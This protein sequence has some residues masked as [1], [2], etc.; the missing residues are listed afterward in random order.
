MLSDPTHCTDCGAPLATGVPGTRCAACLGADLFSDLVAADT[1]V[2]NVGGYV[3]LEEFGRGGMGVVY[4]ARHERLGREAA[5]KLILSGALASGQERQ[6]FL[7][8]MAA[9]AA[10]DHPNIVPVFEAGEDGGQLWYAMRLLAGQSLAGKLRAAPQQPL[11]AREAAALVHTLALAVQHAHERGFIHRDLKPANILLDETGTPH[12]ADFGLARRVD[13]AEHLT[14]TGSTLGT[15]AYMAPEQA[16]G[17]RQVTTAADVYSLGAI[18]YELLAG[19]APF[20]GDSLTDVL[21]A[22]RERDPAALSRTDRDLDI[23]CRKCL[24]KEPARRYPSALALAGD[25]QHWL[26]GKPISARA[27]GRT[28]RLVRWCR[29]RPAIAGLGAAVVLLFLAGLCGVLWQWNRANHEARTAT[30]SQ[31][32]AEAKAKEAR[33]ALYAADMNLAQAA[34]RSNNTGRARRLLDAHRPAPGADDLRGWEWRYLWDQCRSR[35]TAVLR[36]SGGA[37]WGVA[38]AGGR[39]FSNEEDGTLREFDVDA[40]SQVKKHRYGFDKGAL[41][42]SPDGRRFIVPMSAEKAEIWSWPEH[43]V[44]ALAV[45]ARLAKAAWSPDGALAALQCEDG[46]VRLCDAI[47]GALR[48]EWK[49][50]ALSFV[51]GGAL[52]FLPGDPLRLAVGDG[53]SIRIYRIEDGALERDW[54]AHPGYGLTSLAASP[55]GRWLVSSA[56]YG[57]STIRVWNAVTGNEHARL[58]AHTSWVSSLVFSL[59]GSRLYGAGADQAISV[60]DAAHWSHLAMLRGHTDEIWSLALAGD[61]LVSGA[62]NGEVMLWS[63]NVAA[64]AAGRFVFPPET[65]EVL[66]AGGDLIALRPGFV[67]RWKPGEWKRGR[68]DALPGGTMKYTL[69][70][71]LFIRGPD[72]KTKI[73]DAAVSPPE[74]IAE[75]DLPEIRGLISLPDETVAVLYHQEGRFTIVDRSTRRTHAVEVPGTVRTFGFRPEDGHLLV[76]TTEQSGE[77]FFHRC[78]YK[79][80]RWLPPERVAAV[81]EGY[82]SDWRADW[83]ARVNGRHLSVARAHPFKPVLELDQENAVPS[84]AFSRDSRWL[85]VA[86]ENAWV[87][88]W[89]LPETGAIPEPAILRGHLNSVHSL[90]FTPDSTRLVTLCSNREAAKFWDPATGQELLT[91]SGDATLLYYARFAAGGTTLLAS[92]PVRGN[93]WQA[94]HAPSLEAIAAEEKRSAW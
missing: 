90:A 28:E 43:S 14:L 50:G 38:A 27:A 2:L 59:D 85:A 8:E 42:T 56:C 13:S 7:G 92:R 39:V 51:H 71:L 37:V 78:D 23:I 6:R 66:D 79:T 29:R 11:P 83:M 24:A 84:L 33:R 77:S 1:T 18:L 15:P 34:L 82:R 12:I 19:R 62:K 67:T 40:K 41:T 26:Q 58:D 89:V 65:H 32:L 68:E 35:A 76:W 22:I 87:R 36:S 46:A 48:H 17:G 45:S 44:M 88:L 20:V 55:D 53:A 4:R 10:L 74:V 3:L 52:A 54:V 86:N 49:L 21:V 47:T 72:G 16:A 57:D 61:G 75:L 64:E 91:L 80:G 9:A 31:Q 93:S 94:W 63:G 25:L 70:A 81:P 30:A 5:V 60:W 73:V 69:G